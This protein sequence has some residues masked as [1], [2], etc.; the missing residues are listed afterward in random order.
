MR[1]RDTRDV[2]AALIAAAADAG[3]VF[4]GILV[5]TWIRFDAG[6]IPLLHP[7]PESR[8]F[9]VLGAAVVALI[10]V[11]IFRSL[12]L[13]ERPQT[14]PFSA[15]VPR[16]VRGVL[17]GMLVAMAIGFSVRTEPP[18]ARLVVGLALPAILLFVLVERALLFRAEI[19]I[20]RRTR[21]FDRVL[22]IGA[23]ATAGR[24]RRAMEREPR[25]RA[26]VLGFLA[27]RPDSPR[28][29]AIA[30]GEVLGTLAD[31][32]PLLKRE[33]VDQVI[34]ADPGVTHAERVE[35][36]LAC[37]RHLA[38][39][40]MVPDLF[41]ILTAAVEVD[42]L[43]GI[44]LLGL[45]RWPLDVFWNRLLKRIE[46]VA[47]ALVGLLLAAPV[48]AWAAVRIKR[49][50]PGPVFF[51]QVRCGEGGHQFTLYKLRTM[52]V[53]AEEQSGPVWTVEDDP[54]CTR[55]GARL[56]RWNLDELPQFW[57]VLRGDMSLVG[58]RPERP[59]FVEKF[60]EGIGRYM[61]RHQCRPGM[62]GWAQVNGLRGNTDIEERI[63]H[64]LYYL[65]NWSLTFDFK[66]LLKTLF[67]RQN[68]Y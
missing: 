48:L 40:R 18:F 61:W 46:D 45:G 64:D 49:E 20:A 21:S 7:V 24:L 11:L 5:A 34:L 44:P 14:G 54:R 22:V 37:D 32:E 8:D 12:G 2:A 55:I 16:L 58:P 60:R 15:R 30:E 39:F 47:G 66:I 67:T 35:V 68:A 1:R 4:G 43:E 10:F 31:L 13:Y 38:A 29:P 6:W 63:R 57:N 42:T 36:M 33:R 65:E 19:A 17:L 59:F 50:S 52:R 28:A 53:D 9:Y 56:R 3:A 26:R 25:L 23:D 27:T 62:T 41:R 51:R